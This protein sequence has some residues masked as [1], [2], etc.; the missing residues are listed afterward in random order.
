MS[1]MGILIQ[2]ISQTMLLNIAQIQIIKI[3]NQSHYHLIPFPFPCY[4]YIYDIHAIHKSEIQ[5]ERNR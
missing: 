3:H 1:T 2:R 4:A 5:I